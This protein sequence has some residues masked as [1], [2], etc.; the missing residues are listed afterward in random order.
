MC[1]GTLV[2]EVS[3]ILIRGLSDYFLAWINIISLIQ[4]SFYTVTYTLRFYVIGLVAQEKSKL[5][6]PIFWDYVTQLSSP[7][8]TGPDF[9]SY[10]NS[11]ATQNIGNFTSSYF[12]NSTL[13][14]FHKSENTHQSDSDV[15]NVAFNSTLIPCQADKISQQIDVYQTFYWLN[16]DRFYWVVWDPISL[17]EAVNSLAII[18]S[19]F[20]LIFLVHLLFQFLR[21][22]I[23]IINFFI[24]KSSLLVKRS[25]HF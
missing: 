12:D 16:N 22:N 19:V 7:I 17:S 11:L 18:T 8:C 6:N 9:A 5:S 24:K 10:L 4:V 13:S 1:K 20:R 25:V 23:Q 21:I 15:S 14:N 3:Q 2:R